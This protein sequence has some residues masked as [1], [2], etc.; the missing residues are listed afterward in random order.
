MLNANQVDDMF[1]LIGDGSDVRPVVVEERLECIYTD[2][3]AAIGNCTELAI[4]EVTRVI[5]ECSA[6]GVRGDYRPRTIL[7]HI[8][9]SR[10][11]E[12]R[13]IYDDPEFGTALYCLNAECR[14][15]ARIARSD[16]LEERAVRGQVPS[17]MGKTEYAQSEPVEDI[18][19]GSVT[20]QW[21][22]TF[23]PEYERDGVRIRTGLYVCGGCR[24]FEIVRLFYFLTE[25]LGNR[26][27]TTRGLLARLICVQVDG[28]DTHVDAT[29]PHLRKEF[30]FDDT[31]IAEF[32]FP[33]HGIED[34]RVAIENAGFL[35]KGSRIE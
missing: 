13:D 32:V 11:V 1:D 3:T 18:E 30:V 19:H 15:T 12:V 34:V 7:D 6:V 21:L 24:E 14:E 5:A 17:A 10:F 16:R 20:F 26:K 29:R 33:N 27:P 2:D 35:V 4:P 8:P 25:R 28:R 31:I 23:H 22:G 9:E